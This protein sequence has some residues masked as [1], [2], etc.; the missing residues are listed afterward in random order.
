MEEGYL[1]TY[2]GR[3]KQIIHDIQIEKRKDF[4]G[5]FPKEQVFVKVFLYNPKTVRRMGYLMQFGV[6]SEVEF[7]CYEIHIDF[8]LQFFKDMEING[9]KRVS[10]FQCLDKKELFGHSAEDP[11]FVKYE[12]SAFKDDF[13]DP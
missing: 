4:Y 12:V 7:R 2:G 5:Y 6:I 9:F 13:L 1:K 11:N 10:L 8:E 3:A